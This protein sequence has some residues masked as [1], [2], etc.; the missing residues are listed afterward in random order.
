MVSLSHGHGSPHPALLELLTHP[1]APALLLDDALVAAFE[2]ALRREEPPGEPAAELVRRLVPELQTVEVAPPLLT[3]DEFDEAPEALSPLSRRSAKVR[4]P[5]E[6][7][8][9]QAPPP[10]PPRSA[11]APSSAAT[12][13]AGV[14]AARSTRSAT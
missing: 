12:S 3:D 11:R 2:E 7:Q 13:P 5:G 10:A 8:R 4:P 6:R 14:A 9:R 1:E